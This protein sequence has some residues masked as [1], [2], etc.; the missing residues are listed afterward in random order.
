MEKK[1]CY[2]CKHTQE[3]SDKDVYQDITGKWVICENCGLPYGVEMH[4]D[5]E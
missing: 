2:S 3:V 5:Y 1:K 4:E